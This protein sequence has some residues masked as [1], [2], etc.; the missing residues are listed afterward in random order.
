[1][2]DPHWPIVVLEMVNCKPSEVRKR[3]C[4]VGCMSYYEPGIDCAMD[5]WGKE[6][7]LG[8]SYCPKHAEMLKEAQWRHQQSQNDGKSVP[9]S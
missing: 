7:Y 5:F 3:C 1:M 8:H 9:P 2:I 4:V 6:G